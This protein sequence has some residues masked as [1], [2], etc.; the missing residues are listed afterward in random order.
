[1]LL[2]TILL[3]FASFAAADD[4][5]WIKMVHD[6]KLSDRWETK[7]NWKIGD[8]GVATLEPRPSDQGWRRYDDYIWSKDKFADFEI[9]FEYQVQKLGNSG[10]YFH[11]GD[12]D[13]PVKQGIEV[14]IFDSF[15]KPADAKLTDHDS[16]GVIPGI[17]PTKNTARPPGK[18]NRMRIRV[19]KQRLN[20]ELNGKVVNKVDLGHPNIKDRPTSGLIGFQDHGLPLKLRNVRVRAL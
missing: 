17:P 12:K 7:G 18:W 14:Q 9:E 19:E 16:G 15:G 5:K 11:V 2:R 1:M 6:G 4:T 3:L 20:V 8:D 13:N 10:F